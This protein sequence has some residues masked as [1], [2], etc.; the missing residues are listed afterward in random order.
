M[1]L[2]REVYFW[3]PGDRRGWNEQCQYGSD[4]WEEEHA[5]RAEEW[6]AGI[7]SPSTLRSGSSCCRRCWQH[8][9]AQWHPGDTV[10]GHQ[11]SQR[12]STLLAVSCSQLLLLPCAVR[13]CKEHTAL[14]CSMRTVQ[15]TMHPDNST[16]MSSCADNYLKKERIAYTKSLNWLT[17]FAWKKEMFVLPHML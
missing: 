16:A 7:S 15:P 8:L 13:S 4:S 10:A 14:C 5:T 2:W 11:A 17:C 3:N 12:V 9:T 1:S 6:W